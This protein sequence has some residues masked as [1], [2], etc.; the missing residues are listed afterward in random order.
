MTG[1]TPTAN[2]DLAIEAASASNFASIMPVDPAA[3]AQAHSLSAAPS[4]ADGAAKK[5]RGSPKR[6]RVR[7][8]Q[9]ATGP[10]AF[11]SSGHGAHY[12][13]SGGGKRAMSGKRVGTPKP[14]S[15]SASLD[16]EGLASGGGGSSIGNAAA[17][18]AAHASASSPSAQDAGAVE[19]VASKSEGDDI[20]VSGRQFQ[21]HYHGVAHVPPA[22]GAGVA[23]SSAS[24]AKPAG[25][26]A[27]AGA[28][29]GAGAA[30]RSSKAGAGSKAA[31]ASRGGD[32]DS[33]GDI[34]SVGSWTKPAG[35]TGDASRARPRGE[36]DIAGSDLGPF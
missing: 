9:P 21:A 26:G 36:G 32:G 16:G 33:V 28:G 13:A 23:A 17:A 18:P 8:E 31:A 14:A 7:G 2:G 20:G 12:G 5:P 3:E 34:G 1:L 35:A 4:G 10:V 24:S 29:A 22:D 19:R 25:G 11:R 27:S 6:A 15:D 30:A